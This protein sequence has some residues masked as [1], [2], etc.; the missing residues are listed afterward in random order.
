MHTVVSPKSK[1]G[2]NQKISDF[3]PRAKECLK[4]AVDEATHLCEK[5]V[6]PEHLFLALCKNIINDPVNQPSPDRQSDSIYAWDGLWYPLNPVDG[7][8]RDILRKEFLVDTSDLMPQVL[9]LLGPG[10]KKSAFYE[11]KLSERPYLRKFGDNVTHRAFIC[12]VGLL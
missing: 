11:Q 12:I 7:V 3:T 6:L 4:L 10:S 8:W 5:V 1:G 9:K 2:R